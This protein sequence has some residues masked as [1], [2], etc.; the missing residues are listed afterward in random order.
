LIKKRKSFIGVALMLEMRSE[1]GEKLRCGKSAT[2]G[3]GKKKS[4]PIFQGLDFFGSASFQSASSFVGV[5]SVRTRTITLNQEQVK[6]VGFDLRSGLIG[7]VHL[8]LLPLPLYHNQRT[9]KRPPI[10]VR[11]GDKERLS[12]V[13]VVASG[14]VGGNHSPRLF[15]S[16]SRQR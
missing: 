12:V 3:I 7:S 16:T 8:N 14:N 6:S 9:N 1:P 5:S 11:K 15:I 2:P 4:S 10:V 13:G